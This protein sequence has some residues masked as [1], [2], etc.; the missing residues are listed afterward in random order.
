[1]NT[2]FAADLDRSYLLRFQLAEGLEDVLAVLGNIDACVLVGNLT[3]LVDDER[4]AARGHTA[5][6]DRCLPEDILRDR[7]TI[8]LR[9]AEFP[10]DLSL[11]IGEQLEIETVGFLEE[12]LVVNGVTT[13]SQDQDVF[14]GKQLLVV[15]VTACLPRS[16]TRHGSGKEEQNDH[17]LFSHQ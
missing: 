16:P 13:D 14:S 8:S 9:D 7:A 11:D 17:L 2:N 6:Q 1:M 15:A 5:S 12:L 4:P 10:G 3:L